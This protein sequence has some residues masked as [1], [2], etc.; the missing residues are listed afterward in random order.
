MK[1]II[2]YIVLLNPL[3]VFLLFKRNNM[4]L[5]VAGL[6]PDFDDID[7]KEMF[8]LYGEVASAKI[9]TDRATGKS[10]G[11]GFIDMPDSNDAKLTI[12]ALDGVGLRGKKLSVKEAEEQQGGGGARRFDNNSNDRFNRGN[13]RYNNNNDRY[14]RGGDSGGYN[15]NNDRSNDRGGSDRFN[16]NSGDRSNDRFKRDY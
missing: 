16:R 15:R 10:K 2:L 9:I 1:Q 4:K 11:F 5:F 7:F 3:F 14:N 6:P 12:E 13:D 8:E